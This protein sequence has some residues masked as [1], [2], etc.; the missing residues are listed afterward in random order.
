MSEKQGVNSLDNVPI[1]P[2]ANSPD[3]KNSIKNMDALAIFQLVRRIKE[4]FEKASDPVRLMLETLMEE[5]A[6][7]LKEK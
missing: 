7:V 1:N 4:D 5:I 2:L 6:Q 3:I